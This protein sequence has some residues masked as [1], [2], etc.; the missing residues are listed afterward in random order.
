MA[1]TKKK[2][3]KTPGR[4]KRRPSGKSSKTSRRS[5]KQPAARAKAPSS[6]T[7]DT[8]DDPK[9]F[10]FGLPRH[11]VVGGFPQFVPDLR[12]AKAIGCLYGWEPYQDFG[13]LPFLGLLTENKQK[14]AAALTDMN[15]R[16]QPLGGDGLVLGIR[17]NPTGGYQ[18]AVGLDPAA[19]A[20]RF[21][22]GRH[23]FSFVA[24]TASWMYSLRTTDPAVLAMKTWKERNPA[25]PLLL[26]GIE[27]HRPGMFRPM[28][29]VVPVFNVQFSEHSDH[30]P[31]PFPFI[32]DSPRG[33]MRHPPK[34][35]E[36]EIGRRRIGALKRYFPL[37]AANLA[38]RIPQDSSGDD[39][40]VMQA[41][42]NLMIS[43][44]LCHADH[45]VGLSADDL[46]AAVEDHMRSRIE[47][48]GLTALERSE[49]VA[50]QME[51]DRGERDSYLKKLN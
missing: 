16:S 48:N 31:P 5:S 1:N 47:T 42:C 8:R 35:T 3:K 40:E 36:E 20:E 26:G 29:V 45:F 22:A 12:A 28:N 11:A 6:T 23:V 7:K 10:D 49:D 17:L 13:H 46:A 19:M 50:R 41:V 34:T 18:L 15:V 43:R 37:T 32:P 21:A 30:E 2:R 33:E 51:L 24:V 44:E 27:A 25:Y 4:K 9:G 39:W 14:M 38:D